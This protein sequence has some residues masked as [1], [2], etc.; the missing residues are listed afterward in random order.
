MLSVTYKLFVPTVLVLSVVMQNA[1]MLNVVAPDKEAG[2]FVC[3]NFF[4][5]SLVLLKDVKQ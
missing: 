3:S 5:S 4:L 1:V 2:V